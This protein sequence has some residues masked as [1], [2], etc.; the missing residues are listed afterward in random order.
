MKARS[1]EFDYHVAGGRRFSCYV[2]IQ[3]MIESRSRASPATSEYRYWIFV[4]NDHQHSPAELESERRHK[5]EVEA[6]VRRAQSNLGLTTIRENSFIAN[7]ASAV[8]L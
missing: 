5:G 7:W 2:V 3:I 1:A 8:P 4:M 6:G